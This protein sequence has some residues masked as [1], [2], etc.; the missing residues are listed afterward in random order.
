MPLQDTIAVAKRVSVWDIRMSNAIVII[1]V[2]CSMTV[3]QIY[4]KLDVL[5]VRLAP[6]NANLNMYSCHCS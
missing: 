6:V 1:G 3:V 2:S 4:M 5:K